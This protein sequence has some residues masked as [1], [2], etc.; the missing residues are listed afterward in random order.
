MSV[1]VKLV[2]DITKNVITSYRTVVIP[3]EGEFV[4]VQDKAFRVVAI[5]HIPS[6]VCLVSL[7]VLCVEI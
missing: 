7:C 2:D 4:K 5:E 3:R 6:S 1:I